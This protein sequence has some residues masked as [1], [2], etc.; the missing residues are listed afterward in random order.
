MEELARDNPM[1]TFLV[2]KFWYLSI[3]QLITQWNA[4]KIMKVLLG[5]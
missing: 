5:I 1:E 2:E 4:K 3:K